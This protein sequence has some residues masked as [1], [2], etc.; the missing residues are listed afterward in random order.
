MSLT[1]RAA[2]PCKSAVLPICP[3][4]PA[5]MTGFQHLCITMRAGAWEPAKLPKVEAAFCRFK[6]LKAASTWYKHFWKP[7]YTINTPTLTPPYAPAH[8]NSVSIPHLVKLG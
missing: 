2:E 7:P 5:G 1:L 4:I 8:P 6:R 3:A